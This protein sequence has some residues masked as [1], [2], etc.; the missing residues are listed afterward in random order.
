LLFVS[1][2]AAPRDQL[3]DEFLAVTERI[4]QVPLGA[5][6]VGVLA[7]RNVAL[8]AMGWSEFAGMP[9]EGDRLDKA[10]EVTSV[11]HERLGLTREVDLSK[12]L[13]FAWEL[14]HSTLVSSVA[15]LVRGEQGSKLETISPVQE[16]DVVC[17]AAFLNNPENLEQTQWLF[18]FFKGFYTRPEIVAR[19]GRYKT[20][21]VE[22]AKQFADAQPEGPTRMAAM[23]TQRRNLVEFVRP[24][25]GV[26]L[27]PASAVLHGEV[28]QTFVHNMTRWE[29]N[30]QLVRAHFGEPPGTEAS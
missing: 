4:P 5:A 17:S 18:S 9:L 28:V 3:L 6:D 12:S 24:R 19:I 1:I 7:V 13:P 29:P 14:V 15:T 22:I 27:R 30:P 21:I 8:G 23:D 2:E 10:I 16:A 26:A 25:L 11:L 20:Q